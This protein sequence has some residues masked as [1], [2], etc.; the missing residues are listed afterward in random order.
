MNPRYLRLAE[1]CGLA[2]YCASYV[3]LSFLVWTPGHAAVGGF[4]VPR[5][6]GHR[7]DVVIL[8]SSLESGNGTTPCNNSGSNNSIINNSSSSNNNIMS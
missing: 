6:A 3:H 7:V 4:T 2:D 8:E 5:H 1:T